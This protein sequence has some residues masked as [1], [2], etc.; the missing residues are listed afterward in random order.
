M[1]EIEIKNLTKT[2]ED[3]VTR[4]DAITDISLNIEKGDIFG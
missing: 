3:K 1:Y 2:F 4:V